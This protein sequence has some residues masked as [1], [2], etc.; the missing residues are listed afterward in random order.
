MLYNK[1]DLLR[2]ECAYSELFWSVFFDIRTEC[3]EIRNISPYLVRMKEKVDQNN[4][5][6]GHFSRSG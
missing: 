1:Q 3:G 6:C 5:E 2:N 4:S